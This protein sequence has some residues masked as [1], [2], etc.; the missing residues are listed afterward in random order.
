MTRAASISVLALAM[1]CAIFAHLGPLHS[2]VVAAAP[3]KHLLVLY[4][5]DHRMPSHQYTD[6]SILQGLSGNTA[7]DID[8]F[9]EFLGESRFTEPQYKENLVRFL[10]EKYAHTRPDV[11]IA[12]DLRA[13]DFIVHQNIPAFAGIPV[14]A[15]NMTQTQAV[16]L[17]RLGLTN[18]VTGQYLTKDLGDLIPLIRRLKPATSSI[19]LIG[20]ASETDKF[21]Y[22]QIHN[23]LERQDPDLRIVELAGLPM[24]QLLERVGAL[25][26]DSVILY[27]MILTDGAGL[28]FIPK[29]ALTMVSHA[30]NVPVFGLADTFLGYGIIGG[31][32]VSYEAAGKKSAELAL[33]IL[34]GESPGAIPITAAA[35]PP[36]RFDWHEL[37]RWGIP[38]IVLPPGSTVINR[39]FSFW[40]S[41]REPIVGTLA[42][43][44]IQTMLIAG[45][46]INL[47]KRRRAEQAVAASEERYR[48]VADYNYDWE[49]WAAP[50]GTMLYV[51]PACERITGYSP[52]EF[53]A[54]HA[55][56]YEI[57]IPE[58]RW[59]WDR[60]KANPHSE[61][62]SQEIQFRIL[63]RNGEL[64]WIDHACQ[65]VTDDK[66]HFQGLRASNRNVT[67]R[68]L[69]E[70]KIQQQREELA[71]VMRVATMGELT[72][73]LAHEL[74]Q[75][76]AAILNY[77]SAGQ[78]FLTGPEPNLSKVSEALQGIIRDE[79]RAAEIIR[80]V[81]AMLRKQGPKY[82]ALDINRV[83]AASIDLYQADAA[84][85]GLSIDTEFA[86][87]LP[88]VLGDEVQLQ[89]V[90]INLTLNAAAAMRH[91]GNGP[92]RLVFRTEAGNDHGVRVSVRDFGAG[93]D[94]RW[95]DRL[96]EPFYTTKAEG[97]GMGLAVCQ[98]II[99]GHGGMIWAE[100]NA[101]GGATFYFTL[102]A[103]SAAAD[104][105]GPGEI[106]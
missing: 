93:F 106:V 31:Y 11:I 95:K 69:A 7:F 25:P 68:K 27:V 105:R 1:S 67:E 50:D 61:L 70:T 9:T 80:R 102:Q 54:R 5:Q 37:K 82:C 38:E 92:P 51:S 18:L 17:E 24:A 57:I 84:L 33:R 81:R 71:H 41:H 103:H 88:P 63:T 28:Q 99:D 53:I 16:E 75:P 44:A 72:S 78:R 19:A 90:I 64:R 79:K 3:H 77:A 10:N 30:A 43:V 73:S 94:E 58:D 22:T 56:R 89:Q 6:K 21:L 40:E 97:F 87:D 74:N 36:Y 59:I 52:Q 13:L 2:A 46:L 26:A 23:A 8:I 32:Q 12:G 76:L 101:D 66:G 86:A 96:F 39:E 15:C 100:N 83:V 45:L 85:G 29:D 14:V 34:D 104:G 60:H 20:G 47:R 91:G 98:N 49:Y 62:Q 4:S 48:T 42:F 55:L 65:P 35:T